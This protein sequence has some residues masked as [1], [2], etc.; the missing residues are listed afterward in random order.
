MGN[1]D[2]LGYNIRAGGLNNCCKMVCILLLPFQACFSLLFL[3]V[4]EDYSTR[5][6]PLQEEEEMLL[7]EKGVC[8]G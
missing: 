3:M 2:F 6:I 4:N 7:D 1:A 5:F 8:E